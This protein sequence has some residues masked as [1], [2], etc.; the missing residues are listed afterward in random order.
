MRGLESAL[1]GNRI[2]GSGTAPASAGRFEVQA[3]LDGS[4]LGLWPRSGADDVRAAL[5]ALEAGERTLAAL[6]RPER[7]R[8]AAL[9]LEACGSDAE[10]ARW[11]GLRLGLGAEE[12]APHLSHLARRAA[13]H[14]AAADGGPPGAT[15]V[16]PDWS[17]LV[18]G[19]ATAVLC[20]LVRGRPVLYLA[21]PRVPEL[22]DALVRALDAS[23]FPAEATAL[24]HGADLALLRAAVRAP[25]VQRAVVSG[26]APR[27]ASV[28]AAAAARAAGA[29]LSI[30]EDVLR[31]RTLALGPDAALH[32]DQVLVEAFGRS[33][34]LSGQ[35]PSRVEAVRC[36]ARA[37]SA[38]TEAL[39]AGL[40]VSPDANHPVPLIDRSALL[41]LFELRARGLD[42]G[43]TLIHGGTVGGREH[44]PTVQPLVFTNVE[45]ELQLAQ[46]P[47]P[48]PL[49]RLMRAH[50]PGPAPGF[51][52]SPEGG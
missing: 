14:L 48:G 46:R 21:D 12:L 6:G 2:G 17:E 37:F 32:A 36:D 11:L 52:A 27:V 25:E 20:E 7:L 34:T 43:A 39:L 9:A 33:A 23:L 31:G 35:L 47:A 44:A 15:V 41:E 1:H 45:A 40:A 29:P 49:L 19:T 13:P 3:A 42:E 8:R 51:G 28:H 38:F 24:L 26:S 30:Q 22:G 10:L 18:L 50:G 5:L 16:L 4:P